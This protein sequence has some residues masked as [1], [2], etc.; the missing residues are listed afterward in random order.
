MEKFLFITDFDGTV[1][2]Q[3][4]FQQ[5]M[6]RYKPKK[7]FVSENKRGFELLSEVFSG[8]NLTEAELLDEIK[9]APIDFSF[10]DFVKFVKRIGGKVLI[11]SAG[12]KYY[13]EN[14]LRFEGLIDEVEIIAN[15]SFYY[16]G[17]IK[18]IRDENSRFY[19]EQFGIDKLKIVKYYKTKFS[20]L[21]YAG[22]SY[23]DFD[24]CRLCDFRFAKKN[25]AKILDLFYIKHMKFINFSEIELILK[26][27]FE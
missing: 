18:L 25:L 10:A 20:T 14:K 13:V 7:A 22:D 21:A 9:H 6:F 26:K 15:E 17:G 23:V 2:A 4:F 16:D 8:L 5:I 11:L 3:D 24:G 12:A 1:T 27:N 19:D